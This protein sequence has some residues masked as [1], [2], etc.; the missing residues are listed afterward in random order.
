MRQR[1]NPYEKEN[2]E[3]LANLLDKF[4]KIIDEE[5]EKA[6]KLKMEYVNNQVGFVEKEKVYNQELYEKQKQLQETLKELK[7]YHEQCDEKNSI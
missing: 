6:I 4:E 7:K 5:Q 1:L 2:L 3:S